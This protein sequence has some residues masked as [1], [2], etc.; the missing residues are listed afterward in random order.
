MRCLE[1]STAAFDRYEPSS[2]RIS[3]RNTSSLTLVVPLKLMRRTY[4][5]WPGSTTSVERQLFGVGSICGHGVDLGEGVAVEAEAQG[6]A[7]RWT[8]SLA[9]TNTVSPG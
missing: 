5:R 2:W 3:R 1:R 8:A 6:H 4:T 7:P 9:V